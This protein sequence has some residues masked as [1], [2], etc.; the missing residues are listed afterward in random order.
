[1]TPLSVQS[2]EAASPQTADPCVPPC[3]DYVEELDIQAIVK[4]SQVTSMDPT[5][6]TTLS[7]AAP[8]P[9]QAPLVYFRPAAIED[10]EAVYQVMHSNADLGGRFP[11]RR[12]QQMRTL[13]TF[14]KTLQDLRAWGPQGHSFRV[15]CAQRSLAR[16]LDLQPWLHGRQAQ[17]LAGAST[18]PWGLQNNNTHAY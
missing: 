6:Y 17:V 9:G 4:S 16:F 11:W 13:C 7:A 10:L 5:S 12:K 3:S 18:N 14:E 15:C 1:M 8:A 2:D